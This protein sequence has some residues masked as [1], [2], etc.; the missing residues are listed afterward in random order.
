MIEKFRRKFVA[1]ATASVFVLLL[2]IFGAINI[3]NFTVVASDADTV[4]QTLADE[5]GKFDEPRGQPGQQQPGQ[6]EPGSGEMGPHSPEMKMSARYF[7][8]SVDAEGNAAVV[9]FKF[10]EQTVTPEGSI[11]WAKEIV[12]GRSTGWTRTYYRYRIYFV[13][14]LTYVSVIDFARELTPSYR[15]LWSSLVGSGIGILVSFLILIPVSKIFV[16]PLIASDKKQKR[17]ISDASHELKTPLTII[18]ANNEII[19]AEQGESEATRMIDKQVGRLTTMVKNLNALAHIDESGLTGKSPFD[20]AAL[21]TDVVDNYRGPFKKK[22]IHFEVEI[23]AKLQFIGDEGSI[24]KLLSILLDNAQKYALTT[25]EF[26]LYH[27][28]E[29]TAIKVINDAEGIEEGSLDRVF[30]RF[31]RS[32]VARSS[33]IE[34]SG[35]G[36]S[37]A[38]EI[39]AKSGG[40]I[41]AKGENGT[42]II[43][44]EL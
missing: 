30:E 6:L 3:V 29:R 17:F 31:Y 16:K 8:V 27:N 12:G 5:G 42:F 40:R 25:A 11:E 22:N 1:Y 15:V 41:R 34:G 38:K 26:H 20:L 7:T 44:A 14:N 32:D 35:I 18:S 19:E 37:I 39:V 2:L 21:C 13:D 4:T 10:T 23:P 43:K 9:S 28:G 36:L 33:G 24:R